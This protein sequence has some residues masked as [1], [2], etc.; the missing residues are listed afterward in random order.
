DPAIVRHLHDEVADVQHRALPENVR[1]RHRLGAAVIAR[2]GTPVPSREH[3]LLVLVEQ[4][5]VELVRPKACPR[6]R[7]ESADEDREPQASHRPLRI[8]SH[9]AT[10]LHLPGGVHQNVTLTPIRTLR[11]SSKTRGSCRGTQSRTLSPLTS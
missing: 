11:P 7:R 4:L 9:V 10:L 5:L 6:G 1:D 2:L 3:L 8:W